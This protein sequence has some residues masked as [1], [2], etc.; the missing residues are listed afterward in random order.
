LSLYP[1]QMSTQIAHR[2]AWDQTKSLK[3][4]GY[5]NNVLEFTSKIA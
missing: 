2:I 5:V 3:L 1:P 4:E